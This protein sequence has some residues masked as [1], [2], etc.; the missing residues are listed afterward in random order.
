MTT[1]IVRGAPLGTFQT[2]CFVV[3]TRSAAGAPLDPTCW[4]VD[5]GEEPDSVLD[6]LKRSG[7][8][9]S[10]IIL[11]HAHAD[12]IAG[13]E[14]ARAVFPDAAVLGHPAERAFYGDP[15]LNLSAFVA[16]PFTAREPTAD[17]AHGQQLE[18]NGTRWRVLHTPGH[19]PGSVTLVC[20]D[21]GVAI[22]GDTLF[23]G[24]IGRV[25]FPTS[26]PE[27]MWRSLNDVL[28]Q[29]PDHTAVHPGHGPSTTIGKERTSN[30]FLQDDSWARG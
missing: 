6:E 13:L 26:D 9:P 7:M 11:T 12:H 10:A 29:L 4:L 28:M 18:L 2:N 1:V 19:S 3:A 17:L 25:D 16:A 15:Q 23:A 22:A 8:T 21:A 20:D 5:P 24:S 27:A 14:R 30:P